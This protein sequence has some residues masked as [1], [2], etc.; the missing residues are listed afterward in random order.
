MIRETIF[1][2]AFEPLMILL[3]PTWSA[4]KRKELGKAIY[5]E[6]KTFYTEKDLLEAVEDVKLSDTEKMSF[7]IIRK[8]LNRAKSRRL[9]A[10][11]ETE[12]R[13]HVEK[14]IKEGSVDPRVKQLIKD[15]IEGKLAKPSTAVLKSNAVLIR[16]DGAR[17]FIWLEINDELADHVIHSVAYREG[18]QVMESYLNLAKVNYKSLT[19]RQAQDD[20]FIPELEI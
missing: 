2:G 1:Q 8:A 14:R 7:P 17:E 5:D 4:A 13:S 18:Q 12:R 20:E 6:I 19:K 10:Q 3:Q 11:D 9:D 15:F 16:K